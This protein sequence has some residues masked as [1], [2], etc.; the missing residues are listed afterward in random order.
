MISTV[1]FDL[2]GLL[3]DSET[4]HC[5]SYQDV[6]ATRAIVIEEDE[7]AEHWIR[8]GLG[9]DEF[10]EARGLDL[11]TVAV[12]RDKAVRFKELVASDLEPMPGAHQVLER[13]AGN[14]RL[15][16]ATGSYG[17]DAFSI[18]DGL[19]IREFF[20]YIAT[21][22]STPRLKPHPDP[23][24]HV[25]E[26]LGV[27]PAECV[28]LEDAEKGVIAA[29]RAGMVSIAVPNRFTRDTDLSQAAVV[30]ESLDEVTLT[31]IDSLDT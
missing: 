2:D 18:I 22:E 26:R 11:D 1:I 27:A 10:A 5:R 29:E 24:L 23:W 28:V 4:L 15:A 17:A 3:A 31:L 21:K 30:L 14:K 16:L 6:L 7:Y 9:I 19:G 25:A 20:E 8:C 13:I 12:R